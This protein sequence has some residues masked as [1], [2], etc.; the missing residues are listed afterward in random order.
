M[1]NTTEKDPFGN[2]KRLLEKFRQA[3][4]NPGDDP[5]FGMEIEQFLVDS[6]TMKT[7]PYEGEDGVEVILHDLRPLFKE[8]TYSEGHLIGLERD[9]LAITIEP[10]AQLEFSIAPMS[11]VGR[12]MQIWEG[13]MEELRPILEKRQ[14]LLVSGGYQPVS[15]IEDLDLIPK[16]RYRF[17]FRHFSQLEGLGPNMMKGTA[18]IHLSVDYYSEDHM[19]RLYRAMYRLLPMLAFMTENSPVFE[20]GPYSRHLLRMKIWRETDPPRVDVSPYLADDDRMTFDRYL[21]FVSGAPVVVKKTPEGEVYSTETI[22]E[23]M[24]EKAF[25]DEGLAHLM[26]MVFPYIRIKSFLE[27]R[28][29]DSMPYREVRAYLLLMK[30]LLTNLDR[31]ERHIER[32]LKGGPFDLDE[33]VSAVEEHGID[34]VLYGTP[35]KDLIADFVDLAA[36]QLDELDASYLNA[37]RSGLITDGRFVKS[38]PDTSVP[39]AVSTTAELNDFSCLEITRD[40]D[41]H[42]LSGLKMLERLSENDLTAGGGPIRGV[43]NPKIYSAR[44]VE[45][46]K[47]LSETVAS[48]GR[49]AIARYRVDPAFRRLFGFDSRLEELI[50]ADTMIGDHIPMLRTDIFYN[51]KNG[52]FRICELN[53]DGSSGMI[54]NLELSR[55]FRKTPLASVFR[56]YGNLKPFELFDSLADRWLYLFHKTEIDCP[57]PTF[58]IVD[59][60]EKASSPEEFELYRSCFEAKGIKAVIADI[61]DLQFDGDALTDGNGTKIDAVYRRAVTSDI[62]ADYDNVQSFIEAFRQKKVCLLGGFA[63]TVVHDKAFLTAVRDPGFQEVLTEE[64]RR[65]IQ[66]HLPVTAM[67]NDEALSRYE[68]DLTKDRWVLKPLASYGSEGVFIGKD[69]SEEEWRKALCKCVKGRY[70]LQAYVEPWQSCHIDYSADDPKCLPYYNMTG[71]YV[72]DGTFTGV[73]SRV[74]RNKIISTG[75]GGFDAA[76]IMFR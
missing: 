62:M 70:L 50:L 21:D 63:T 18:S 1:N 51:E 56:K 15:R 41:E 72:Y 46:F 43:Y 8:P 26:S 49:K 48:I 47:H 27:I 57:E 31:T 58:A 35:L 22:G 60:L 39:T 40:P 53:T 2:R 64:E 33:A 5:L 14:V 54:E 28:V 4:K 61:R 6:R 29:A 74:S 55:Q 13:M 3:S 30:G 11:D 44:A 19:G 75:R 67:L 32:W 42:R 23:L 68:P 20:G 24:A 17:M 59:F 12:I 73:Y 69:L 16:Q 76:S 9:D 34:A 66:D 71:L 7:I 38:R 10:A 52:D 25:D 37:Y 65:L 36:G 45:N